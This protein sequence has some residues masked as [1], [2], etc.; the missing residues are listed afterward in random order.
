[1][2]ADNWTHCPRCTRR[3]AALIEAKRRALPK[4]Y[5]IGSV[6]E[7]EI[8]RAEVLEAQTAYERRDMTFRGD[9]EISG[10]ETGV[11][12]VNY[13]GSCTECGLSLEFDYRR[14]IPGWRE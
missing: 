10:A 1:M 3:K 6:E 2:S 13:M 7:F 9:Y 12:T 11:V 4:L 5:G 8:A 14:G